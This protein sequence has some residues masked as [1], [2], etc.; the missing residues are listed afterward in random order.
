[1]PTIRGTQRMS[2]HAVPPLKKCQTSF[3]CKCMRRVPPVLSTPEMFPELR[4][5]SFFHVD[6][7]L[8]T[9]GLASFL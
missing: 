2:V 9:P 8:E 3:S 5:R 7:G 6:L 4:L 1:M